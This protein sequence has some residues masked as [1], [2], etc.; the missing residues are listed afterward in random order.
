MIDGVT[1]NGGMDVSANFFHG[2]HP[3]ESPNTWVT[4]QEAITGNS[5]GGGGMG[6]S[7]HLIAATFDYIPLGY[8]CDRWPN[9]MQFHVASL[10]VDWNGHFLPISTSSNCIPMP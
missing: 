6:V 7:A 3:I 1:I 4:E 10:S 8:P 5:G 2:L 9:R